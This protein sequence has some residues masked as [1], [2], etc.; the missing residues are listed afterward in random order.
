MSTPETRKEVEYLRSLPSI[1]AR[2]G[3]VFERGQKGELRFWDL[4]L[5][6]EEEIVGFC[7]GLIEVR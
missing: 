2:C 6:K 1:R 3:Q 7:E 4:D 5:G